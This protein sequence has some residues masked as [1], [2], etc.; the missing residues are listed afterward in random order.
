MSTPEGTGG[1]EKTT[2]GGLRDPWAALRQRP[3]R[4]CP[5][6]QRNRPA[7]FLSLGSS[8]LRR[9]PPGA[10]ADPR[11]PVL[12]ER[13]LFSDIHRLQNEVGSVGLRPVDNWPVGRPVE[14]LRH[15]HA[16]GWASV[17]VSM[18][19]MSAGRGY[20]Y[21]LKSVVRGD[22]DMGRTMALTRCYTEEG[23]PTG[24]WLGS[25]LRALGNGE[26]KQGDEVTPQQLALLPT[27]RAERWVHPAGSEVGDTGRTD[28]DAVLLVRDERLRHTRRA[29]WPGLPQPAGAAPRL[30][31]DELR[32]HRFLAPV[33]AD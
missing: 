14:R 26:I 5:P 25:G 27:N 30:E 7:F 21:L 10:A 33:D 12:V 9:L 1:V 19:V 31:R 2:C 29:R 22:R 3:R 20:D 24:R 11:T 18:R 13:L 15:L 17:T 4:H 6:V 8:S 16:R 28:R 32:W 23:T